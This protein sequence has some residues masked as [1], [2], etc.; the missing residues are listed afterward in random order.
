[1]ISSELKPFLRSAEILRHMLSGALF[2]LAIVALVLVVWVILDTQ[3]SGAWLAQQVHQEGT[4]ISDLQTAGLTVILLG[5]VGIWAA[6]VWQARLIFTALLMTDATEASAAARRTAWLLWA[7]V[8]WGIASYALGTVIASW[9]QP[10]GERTLAVS[11]GTAQI[12]AIFAAL[13][14]S[15]SSHAFGL[16]AALWQD[17]REVI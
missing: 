4:G 10:V 1:M 16:G 7:M 5:H 9:H 12:S 8:I 3:A 6:V 14:A 13:L 2:L 15:F 11:I 17:H